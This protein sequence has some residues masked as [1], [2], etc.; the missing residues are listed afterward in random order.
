MRITIDGQSS[1]QNTIVPIKTQLLQQSNDGTQNIVEKSELG[2]ALEHLN[3][4]T[5]DLND[6]RMSGIDMRARLH[7]TEIASVLALDSLVS[8]G[9]CP[10]IAIAFT[11]QKKRLSVSIEGAGRKDIVDIVAGKQE[12]ENVG[13]GFGEKM[14]GLFG[15]GGQKP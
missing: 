12:R 15:I 10:T 4:D 8:L 13:K 9:V 14:K 3:D 5:I 2:E 1:D 6:S 11:R 7:H